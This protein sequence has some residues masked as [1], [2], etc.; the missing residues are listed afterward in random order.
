MESNRPGATVQLKVTV[1]NTLHRERE[2]VARATQQLKDQKKKLAELEA[3][4]GEKAR[5]LREGVGAGALEL[6]E[7][8]LRFRKSDTTV[9]RFAL[10]WREAP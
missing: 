1:E 5:A 7:L 6:D 9:E 3:E 4:F 8:T 10:A 2:D